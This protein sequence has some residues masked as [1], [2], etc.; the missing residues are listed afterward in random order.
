LEVPRGARPTSSRAREALFDILRDRIAGS[1]VLDLYAGS[2]AVG[3]EAVSRGA[4]RAVFVERESRALEGNL[5]RLGAGEGEAELRAQGTREAVAALARGGERFDVIFCDPPYGQAEEPL[6]R[7]VARLL[8]PGGLLVLQTD[9][10]G[11][12]PDVAGLTLVERRPY[13]RNV[14]SFFAPSSGAR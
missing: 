2:G 10:G 13:G 9:S 5:A 1:R 11:S 7:P 6:P 8:A 12:A 14:L 3:L 4:A